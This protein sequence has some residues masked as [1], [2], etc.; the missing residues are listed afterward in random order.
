MNS[1]ITKKIIRFKDGYYI[2]ANNISKFGLFFYLSISLGM[3]NNI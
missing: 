3:E 1:S 2:P